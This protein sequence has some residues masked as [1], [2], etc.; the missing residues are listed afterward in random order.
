M[1]MMLKRISTAVMW[2]SH[3]EGQEAGLWRLSYASLSKMKLR[4]SVGLC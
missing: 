4:K 3:Y 1:A 2:Q